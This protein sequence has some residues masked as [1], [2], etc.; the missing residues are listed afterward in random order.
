MIYITDYVET[1]NIEK[2]I[3][4]EKLCSFS[5]KNVDKSEVKVILV[6]HFLINERTLKEFPN[7]KAIV[8]YGT[9]FDN[10][11]LDYCK[12]NNIKVF[13][14]PDYGVDEVSDSALALIMSLS[15]SI[16]LYD[17]KAKTLVNNPDQKKPWQENTNKQ[18][19][20][21]K[22]CNL[23]IIGVGRIGSALSLKMKNIVGNIHFYD[24]YVT[25][26]YEKVLGAKRHSS[27]ENLLETSDIVSMHIPLNKETNGFINDNFVEKMKHGAILVNTAR[28]G[29]LESHDCIFKG[30]ESGKLYGVGLDVLPQEPPIFDPKDKFIMAWLDRIKGF[31]G[32]ILI[33]PHSAYYS[34]ESYVEM[35][36]NAAKMALNALNDNQ[37]LN[38]IT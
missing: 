37:F 5:Q 12:K 8:R 24:P 1:P 27:L 21:L 38:R 23:G 15:R 18:A 13:N 34:Q 36:S 31:E 16:G 19:L 2:D 4:K 6:W 17:S 33:N 3:V 22:N 32:R 35:R 26:G 9:G 7:V 29:L 20:R 28:G 25:S 11:D 10:I 14:N 30:L